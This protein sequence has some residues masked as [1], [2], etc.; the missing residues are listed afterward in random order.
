[1]A[2]KLSKRLAF[3]NDLINSDFDE[4][5]DCCCDHGLL[6]FQVL[7]QSKAKKVH[8][9]DRVSPLIDTISKK[10]DLHFKPLLAPQSPERKDQ[11]QQT[12][13][14][15]H[16]LD[17]IVQSLPLSA[18]NKHLLIIA[19]IGGELLINMLSKIITE[20]SDKAFELIICP[21]N[22][23]YSVR[24]YLSEV[25]FTLKSEHIVSENKRF[26]EVLHLLPPSNQAIAKTEK[27]KQIS[28]TG[29]EQWNLTKASHQKYLTNLLS[30]YQ[31]KL[32][33]SQAPV[34]KEKLNK[35]IADYSKL[36]H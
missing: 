14:E 9:V 11:T 6:G 36:N 21:V 4:I 32:N 35:I 20:H 30:H 28:P 25:E 17:L 12:S 26:Y 27:T 18:N 10:L 3:I 16:A 5:W 22:Q 13:Y 33:G 2:I 15:L 7:A 29:E 34:Q 24:E 8:F 19:G 31:N 23:L 1:M